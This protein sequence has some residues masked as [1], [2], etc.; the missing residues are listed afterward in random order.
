MEHTCGIYEIKNVL[1]GD[2]CQN[3][4]PCLRLRLMEMGVITDEKIF[5]SGHKLGLWIVNLLT[6]NNNISSTIVLRDDEFER[7]C[8]KKIE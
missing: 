4:N 5:I 8:L 2:P 1:E 7:I 6:K 3:C